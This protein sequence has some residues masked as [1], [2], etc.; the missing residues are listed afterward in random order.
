M[1]ESHRIGKREIHIDISEGIS[2]A[3]SKTLCKGT[4]P[5]APPPNHCLRPNNSD[6]TA[7]AFP[8]RNPIIASATHKHT[9]TDTRARAHTAVFI[10]GGNFPLTSAQT[11]LETLGWID[12]TIT[13]VF[14]HS[15]TIRVDVQDGRNCNTGCLVL[16]FFFLFVFFLG[17]RVQCF[18]K[19]ELRHQV[20]TLQIVAFFF[21]SL[22]P[23]FGRKLRLPVHPNL[24]TSCTF[25]VG[26]LRT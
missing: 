2:T 19:N 18:E 1:K 24:E 26:I 10:L 16:L 7:L 20:V 3:G 6:L 14:S 23:E 12:K 25:F 15:F 11:G 17:A 4:A 9:R 5:Q 8:P 22:P 21:L 13:W